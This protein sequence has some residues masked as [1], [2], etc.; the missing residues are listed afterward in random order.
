MKKGITL[1]ISG[2]LL[3]LT[4]CGSSPDAPTGGV[5]QISPTQVV[6]TLVNS[7]TQDA[8]SGT[9]LQVNQNISTT[10][11]AVVLQLSGSVEH[12]GIGAGIDFGNGVGQCY[13]HANM[14]SSNILSSCT[15]GLVSGSPISLVSG[16]TL[17]M[18]SYVHVLSDDSSV[19]AVLQGTVQ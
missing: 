6:V 10:V 5:T 14:G 18:W 3:V 12:A 4:G 19:E 1:G 17:T 2:C 8:A 15:N 11:P 7:G 16:Q 9:P 13:Y